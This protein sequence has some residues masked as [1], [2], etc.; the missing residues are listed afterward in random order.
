MLSIFLHTTKLSSSI[1]VYLVGGYILSWE[2]VVQWGR[3]KDCEPPN[4]ANATIAIN[5]YLKVNN[6]K[7]R[8]LA[9]DYQEEP[10]YLVVTDRKTDVG[11]RNRFVPL[12]ESDRAREIKE[13]LKEELGDV[14]YVTI[15]DP[16][17]NEG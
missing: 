13:V 12:V 3:L 1:M 9:V 14:E 11:S 7:T 4:R 10:M 17:F 2:Q 6:I 8:L 16:Y 5:H 15:A